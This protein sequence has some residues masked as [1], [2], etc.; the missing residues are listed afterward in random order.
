MVIASVTLLGIGCNDAYAVVP[1]FDTYV[2]DDPDDGDI[3]FSNGDTLT[4]TFDSPTNA[5]G[6]GL[7]SR[8]EINANFTDGAGAPDFGTT[9][10]GVWSADS[11]TL[12]I[13]VTDVTGENLAIGVDTIAGAAGTNIAG[14][15]GTNADLISIG[16]DTATLSGD[17]GVIS[18]TSGGGSHCNGDCTAPTLGL[19]KTGNRLV[20]N[21]F[22][23]NGNP[24]NV[25][26][27]YTHYPLITVDV[28]KENVA[29]FKIY[30]DRGPQSVRHFALAFGIGHGKIFSDSKAIIEWGKSW[31]GD[32][33]VNVIDPE[34]SLDNVKIIT[35]TGP[36]KNGD[37]LSND[38]LIIN[39]YHTFRQSLDFNIVG[40]YVWDH[41]RN[42]ANNYYNDGVKVE[43]ESLNPPKQHLAIHKGQPVTITEIEDNFGIDQ[44]S[45]SWTFDKEWT[46]DYLPQGKIDDGLTSKGIDRNNVK[47]NT[48]KQGQVLIA[49][50]NLKTSVDGSM[51]H[52]K[53]VGEPKSYDANYISRSDDAQIQNQI[54][55]EKNRANERFAEHFVVNTEGEL[56]KYWN[57]Y[58]EFQEHLSQEIN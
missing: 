58:K 17:F 55:Y 27:F 28:G 8:V 51:I 53:T 11:R 49:E 14:I 12:V 39:V 6:N 24:V 36:C 37:V 42:G 32:E 47:F 9:Y 18:P 54:E 3:V 33:K 21:G 50:Y 16:G 19:T 43:G 20:E 45:N 31:N 1:L 5:T 2:A 23:Y 22:S 15:A 29:T 41:N 7:I 56:D 4:I 34:N 10:S 57:I 26:S 35:S 46:M 38:C 48:Y 30:E 13:T 25:D 40:T 52:S 44:E